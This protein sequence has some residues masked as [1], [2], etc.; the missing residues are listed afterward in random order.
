MIDSICLSV[1]GGYSRAL[2]NVLSRVQAD[3]LYYTT[4]IRVDFA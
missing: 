3:K 2:A 4:L 1:R